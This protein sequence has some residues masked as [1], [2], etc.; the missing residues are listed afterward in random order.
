MNNINKYR[1]ALLYSKEL[2][3]LEASMKNALTE[4]ELYKKYIPAQE[5]IE[6]ISRNLTIVQ[7]HLNHQKK[8]AESKGKE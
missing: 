8:I 4:L 5:C 1:K 7:V 6:V 3:K 2:A